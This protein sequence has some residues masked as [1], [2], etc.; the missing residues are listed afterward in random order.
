MQNLDQTQIFFQLGQTQLTQTKH[1]LVDEDNLNDLTWFQPCY[2][3][4][5]VYHCYL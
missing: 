2:K 3:H 5:S 4:F 1:Y